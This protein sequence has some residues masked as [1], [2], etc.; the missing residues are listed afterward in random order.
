MKKDSEILDLIDETDKVFSQ[1][2]REEAHL[3]DLLHRQI[4]VLVLNNQNELFVQ[5]RSGTKDVYPKYFEGS[6]S[7]HVNSKEN[8][9]QAAIR[10]LKE[11]LGI[12]VTKPL[13]GGILSREYPPYPVKLFSLRLHTAEEN[14]IATC[15]V[16]KD[17][18][19]MVNIDKSEVLSGKFM[20]LT[21]IKEE[22]KQGKKAFTPLF[23]EAFKRFCKEINFG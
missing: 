14:V 20:K 11:E 23:A 10:E 4:L 13:P 8:Y 6:L 3:K 21:E 1:C 15:F 9:L 5:Q 22:I 2:T 17:Y 7:G 16:L 18:S 19:G 12:D